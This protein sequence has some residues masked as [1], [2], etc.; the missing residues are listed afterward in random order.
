[1]FTQENVIILNSDDEDDSIDGFQTTTLD[2]MKR[3]PEVFKRSFNTKTYE[4]TSDD[5]D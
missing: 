2:E 5:S 1:L 4:S 3:W